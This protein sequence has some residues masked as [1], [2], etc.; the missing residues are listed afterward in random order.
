MNRQAIARVPI[1]LIRRIEPDRSTLSKAPIAR[2]SRL[3]AVMIVRDAAARKR[4]MEA[5][6]SPQAAAHLFQ[7]NEESN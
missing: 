7:L 1:G 5:S 3:S 4:P 2:G 6:R